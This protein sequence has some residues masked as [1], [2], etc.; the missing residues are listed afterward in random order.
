MTSVHE[1]AE[2]ETDK[3]F[4]PEQNFEPSDKRILVVDDDASVREMLA[5]VLAGEGYRVGSAANGLQA[6]EMVSADRFDLV[7]LDLNMPGK[8]GWD[9]FEQLTAGN[10]LISII[11]ITAK[12]NQLFT[13]MSA[14]VGALME[15][16]LDF[17]T[18]LRTISDL[19]MEPVDR[20]LARLAGVPAGFHYEPP[21]TVQRRSNKR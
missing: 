3:E 10:P 2:A 4:A 20:R 14:G 1:K 7:L 17:P 9:T 16:P 15:K 11:I 21:H 13:A 18:L 19:L 6:L 12:P 5:R 8:N